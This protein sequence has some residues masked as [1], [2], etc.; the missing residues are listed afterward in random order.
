MCLSLQRI[1]VISF[2]QTTTQHNTTQHNTTQHNTTQHGAAQRNTQYFN[3][4]SHPTALRAAHNYVAICNLPTCVVRTSGH[5]LQAV[6][7]SSKRLSLPDN[8]KT[9]APHGKP[10]LFSF[11]YHCCYYYYYYYYYHYY[12]SYP[13]FFLDF[14]HMYPLQLPSLHL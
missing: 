3:S 2:T 4:V 13:Y 12:Y 5:I 14:N 11:S 6:W 7:H 9:S 10:D 8:S 1:A